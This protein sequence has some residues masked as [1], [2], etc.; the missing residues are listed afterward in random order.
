MTGSTLLFDPLVPLVVLLGLSLALFA[1]LAL[2][3]A[4]RLSGWPWRGGAALCV[5]LALLNPSVK[6]EE[7]PCGSATLCGARCY[8][9]ST[10]NGF[11]HLLNSSQ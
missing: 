8:R 4:R 3:V 5:F 2:A 1:L 11:D 7:R 10:L 6:T 9:N